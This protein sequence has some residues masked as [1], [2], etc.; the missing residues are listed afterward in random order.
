M[1]IDTKYLRGLY[2]ADRDEKV[3]P[4]CGQEAFGSDCW[5][6]EAL[7]Q[8]P[9]MLDEID[10]LRDVLE[11]IGAMIEPSDVQNVELLRGALLYAR[12]E[13]WSALCEWEEPGA[14]KP[15]NG[16]PMTEYDKVKHERDEAVK[17]I[18][19]FVCRAKSDGFKPG[20]YA[21]TSWAGLNEIYDRVYRK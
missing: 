3:C 12:Q 14:I 18:G 7:D 1:A 2:E 8:A 5:Q 11:T 21:K 6:I 19:D 10:H 4:E 13:A 20:Y 15:L 17:W 16:P 9:E